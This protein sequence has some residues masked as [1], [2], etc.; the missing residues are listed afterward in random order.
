MKLIRFLSLIVIFGAVCSCMQSENSSTSD[1]LYGITGDAAGGGTARL[2][3]L[4]NCSNCHSYHT[5]T[6]AQLIGDGVLD[7]SGAAS[8]ALY[9]RLKGSLSGPGPKN[10]PPNGGLTA[11]DIQDIQ[12]W[13]ENVP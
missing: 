8:S 12:T 10:M 13:A 7:S 2:V 3:L 9:Y 5:M 4:N 11:A 6:Q 1:S